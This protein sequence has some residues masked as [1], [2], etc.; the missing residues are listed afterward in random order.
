VSGLDRLEP[1]DR[2]TTPSIIADRVRRLI[3][4]GTFAPGSQLGEAQLASRLQVSRGPVREAMQRLIQEGL[5]HSRRHRG[6]F[7][8]TFD[9]DD[10]ADI[11][12]AR[13]A[14]ELTAARLLMHRGDEQALDRLEECVAEMRVAGKVQEWKA[15]ADLDLTFHETLV[16]SSGSKR[17]ARMFQTLLVETRICLGA[18]APAYPIPLALVEEHRALVAAM[19]QG[20]EEK[21]AALVDA[22]MQ[23][24]VEVL[25]RGQAQAAQAAQ[26]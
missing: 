20:D 17:L 6:V 25:G 4:D 14:V 19:R 18:L 10:I 2:E 12:L 13:S 16:S 8:V 11:Y 21:L 1:V 22:H 23:Q 7:V 24:A 15:L 26:G 5:L 9:P 3:M